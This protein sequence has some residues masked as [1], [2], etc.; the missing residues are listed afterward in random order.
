ML[1][2]LERFRN[3]NNFGSATLRLSGAPK[4]IHFGGPH[5]SQ[6]CT[7]CDCVD[8]WCFDIEKACHDRSEEG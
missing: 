3:E 8:H 7:S 5:P 6:A 1:A 2:S 4:N